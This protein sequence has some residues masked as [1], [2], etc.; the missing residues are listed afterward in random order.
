VQKTAPPVKRTTIVNLLPEDVGE[1]SSS[2]RTIRHQLT[3]ANLVE[4][5]RAKALRAVAQNDCDTLGEVLSCVSVDEWSKWENKAGQNLVTLSEVR[6][7]SGAYAMLAGAMGLLK[8]LPRQSFEEKETVWVFE[9]GEV[10]PRRATVLEVTAQ[11][12]ETVPVEFWDGDA[13]S[14]Y[15]ERCLVRKMQG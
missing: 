7:S 9:Q 1:P 14:V 5:F 2:S 10:M 13:P 12:A 3:K 4:D 6:R 8:E 11:D 15:V